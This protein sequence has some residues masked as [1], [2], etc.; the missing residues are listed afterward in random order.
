MYI[1]KTPHEYDL[2]MN[3]RTAKNELGGPPRI[4]LQHLALEAIGVVAISYLLVGL[5]G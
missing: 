1:Q 3:L 5:I 2:S 4:A